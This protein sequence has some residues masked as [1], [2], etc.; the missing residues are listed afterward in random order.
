MQ[1]IKGITLIEVLV[2]VVLFSIGIVACY[3]PLLVSLDA[4][5]YSEERIQADHVLSEAV[6]KLN[7]KVL[8]G[9]KLHGGMD[10]VS[11]DSGLARYQIQQIVQYQTEDHRL[12]EVKLRVSWP[13]S[14]RSK[15]IQGELCLVMLERENKIV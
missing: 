3:R 12:A 10:Q 14:D 11:I 9:E 1:G 4:L 6:W 15:A 5:Q 2:S 8:R 7:E 13:H